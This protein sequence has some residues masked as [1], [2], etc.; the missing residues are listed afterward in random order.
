[1]GEIKRSRIVYLHILMALVVACT[2]V[3]LSAEDRPQPEKLL[4]KDFH[5]QSVYKMPQ[6]TVSKAQYPA[7][8]MH[9]HIYAKTPEQVD[10]WVRMMDE[11]GVQKAIVMTMATGKEFD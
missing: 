10:E 4:L 3:G 1:M 6:T 5:P 7:I 11:T 2:A 9:A 8:D